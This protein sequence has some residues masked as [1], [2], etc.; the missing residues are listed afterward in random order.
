MRLVRSWL[1]ATLALVLALPRVMPRPVEEVQGHC[2]PAPA[3][4]HTTTVR[5][6]TAHECAA[7]DCSDCNAV[8]CRNMTRC[9]TASAA[10]IASR[11]GI[12]ADPAGELHSARLDTALF[13]RTTSPPTPP[14]IQL[15]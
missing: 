5:A 4:A 11:P 9:A 13:S 3:A 14:P 6:P 8:L 7:A 1:G 10:A 15:F 12:E 2:S